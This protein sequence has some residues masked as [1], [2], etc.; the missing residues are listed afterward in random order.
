MI[1]SA[2]RRTDIPAFYADWF[3]NRVQVGYCCVPNPFNPSQV[4]RVS[5]KPQD[6]DV[7]VFWT[8]NP[9][10]LVNRLAEL[11]ALGYRYYFL[12]T[13]T[14]Y[15]RILEPRAPSP[16]EAIHAFHVLAQAVGAERV[17][18]RYDPIIVSSLT[19]FEYHTTNFERLCAALEGSTRRVI[20]SLMDDY[21]SVAVRLN[22]L[23]AQGFS[24]T[25]HPETERG[26]SEMIRSMVTSARNHGIEPVSCAEEVDLTALGV[27]LGK[28][29]DDELI[30]RLFGIEVTHQKDPGQRDTCRCVISKD[31]GVYDTCQHGCVY[32]Y[33]TSSGAKAFEHDPSSP[34]LIGHYEC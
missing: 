10:P 14:G 18:W 31:I 12:F 21:K 16:E 29:I 5:L 4:M 33:A 28:C 13:L 19:P 15:P 2:S 7:I 27:N 30:G 3:M 17:I 6:V 32:C 26:F 11:D 1:V 23:R 8:R 25:A 22:R 34:S 24:Y 20:I 9:L